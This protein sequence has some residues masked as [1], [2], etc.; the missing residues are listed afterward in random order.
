MKAKSTL[1]FFPFLFTIIMAGAQS[2]GIAKTG[3][4]DAT[5]DPW[6]GEA[7]AFITKMEYDFY[8]TNNQYRT[9]NAANGLGFIIHE[10]GFTA[11]NL[12]DQQHQNGWDV[13]FLLTGIGRSEANL[14][15]PNG[16]FRKDNDLLLHDFDF[17]RVEYAN[18]NKGMRQNF[19]I[20]NKPGG[21]GNLRVEMNLETSLSRKLINGNKLVFYSSDNNETIR[22]NYDDLN[23][24]DANNKTLDAHMELSQNGNNFSIVVDD[25]N[26]V[27]PITIDPLNTSPEWTTSADGILPGL[28]NN[29][30]LQV[31]TLYGYTVTNLG[32]ID[33]DGYDDVAVGAPGMADVISGSGSLLNVGAVFIYKGSTTGFSTTPSKVLQPT[34]AGPGALFGF[35]IEAGNISADGR[36]DLLIGAPLDTYQTTVS[37]LLGNVNVNVKAGKVYYYR[38]EDLFVVANPSPFLQIRL[39]GDNFFG[40]GILGLLDNT[41]VNALFGYSIGVSEDLNGDNRQDI[42]IG[43]PAYLGK[44]L[45]SVQSGAAFVYYSNNLA[46]TSPVQLA[47]PTP[48]ILGLVSLPIANLNGLLFGFSVEGTGDYNNDGRPDVVVG[49]PAGINL[50]NAVAFTPNKAEISG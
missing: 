10:N 49:A 32:D 50:N 23:V 31:T 44:N 16:S 46:T 47:V 4:P 28:L 9:T 12:K 36:N 15:I 30:A 13:R 21:A 39:Q 29:L 11:F 45:L 26:A 33:G 5:Q 7:S 14:P 1:L 18:T 41:D 38:S 35:S 20:A 6:Y 2:T 25:R 8:P 19:I 34:S 42:I 48:S 24:W 40:I 27:Y 37:G 22:L 3:L 43:C 17:G